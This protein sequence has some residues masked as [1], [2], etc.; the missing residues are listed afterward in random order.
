MFVCTGPTTHMDPLQLVNP[1]FPDY[2]P[3]VGTR[4]PAYPHPGQDWGRPQYSLGNIL[5]P[6][7][8]DFEDNYAAFA[9]PYI[10]PPVPYRLISPDSIPPTYQVDEQ[11]LWQQARVDVTA[12]VTVGNL[13]GP[14]IGD[15]LSE[16]PLATSHS[17]FTPNQQLPSFLGP[18]QSVFP[19]TWDPF[20]TS[21]LP[22]E[23]HTMH[24]TPPLPTRRPTCKIEMPRVVDPMSPGQILAYITL[25]SGGKCACAWEDS[26]G[27]TCEFRSSVDG[28]KRHVRTVHFG[29]K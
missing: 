7:L 16:S 12:P 11:H 1:V 6:A 14:R 25:L 19:P 4:Q 15:Y 21:P 8:L 2:P 29:V 5:P 17:S 3:V 23:D 26:S 18:R 10:V 9:S 20:S 24:P 27:G 22:S 13:A 28:V